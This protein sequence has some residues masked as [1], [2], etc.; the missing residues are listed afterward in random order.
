MKNVSGIVFDIKRYAVHD[1]PGIRTTVFLKGCPAS[2]WWCHNPESQAPEPETTLRTY[3]VGDKIFEEQEDVGRRMSVEEVWR[4]VKKEIV[5][6]E[7]SGGG[8]TFSGGEPLMQPEFL[9]ALLTAFGNHGVHR[10]LDTTGFAPPEVFDGI[11]PLVDLFLF[12]LKIMDNGLHQIYTGVSNT[13]IM[14]NLDK[15]V[16][17]GTEL[18]LRIPVIPDHTDTP[19]NI[20]ALKQFAGTINNG[21]KEIDLLPF[22]DIAR[23]K[24]HRFCKPDKFSAIRKPEPA[25]MEQLKL[26]F[27]A[28]G[29]LVKIGG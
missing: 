5:F 18:I 3:P 28:L 24:Y 19:D 21:V 17:S 15:A 25:R 9:G 8:V 1:G 13:P 23:E 12:D 6:A 16:K 14:R 27:E 2:C 20:A 26:E 11:L 7:S 29:F 4:E 22:H 10:A